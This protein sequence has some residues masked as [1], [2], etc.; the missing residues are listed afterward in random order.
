M[1]KSGKKPIRFKSDIENK[2][3]AISQ[4]PS[5]SYEDIPIDEQFDEPADKI[6]MPAPVMKLLLILVSCSLVIL[7]WANWSNLSPDK[8]A[9]WMQDT[10]LGIG[11]SKGF[12]VKIIGNEIK[13]ANFKLL[14]SDVCLVSDT[15]FFAVNRFAK[16]L[17]NRQ[18]SFSFPVLTVDGNMSLIY[19]RGGKGLQIESISNEIQK[20]SYQNN[21]QTADISNSGVYAV[22]TESKNYLSEMTIYLSDNTERYKYY[23]SECYITDID[24]NREGTRAL[25]VG[26][27]ARN[28]IM[29]EIVYLFD[30]DSTEPLLKMEFNGMPIDIEFLDNNKIAVLSD[31]SLNIIDASNKSNVEIGYDKKLLVSYDIEKNSK[32]CLALSSS[33]DGR[34]CDLI[35]VDKNGS[36][37]SEFKTGLKILSLSLRENMIAVLSQSK[38]DIYSTKGELLNQKDIGNDAKEVLLYSKHD[39]YV[40]GVS[41]VRKISF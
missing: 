32:I 5:L 30:F 19:N 2:N 3:K 34:N 36:V 23:F 22:V 28:G 7:I 31:K 13:N 11:N 25:A 14:F 39:S 33:S 27:I 6:Q 41:E 4:R 26:A 17:C 37:I 12:P 20:T 16:P 10:V 15:S 1:K 40:L 18:H 9:L 8:V 35:F 24:I 38:L 21:I 29:K